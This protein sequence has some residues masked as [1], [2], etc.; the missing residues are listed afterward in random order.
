[1]TEHIRI[2][3]VGP[4]RDLDIP[5]PEGGGVVVLRALNGQGKTTAIEAAARLAGTRKSKLTHR[6]GSAAGVVEGLGATIAVRAT[7]RRTGEPVLGA[8]QVV[9][10]VDPSGLVDPGLKSADAADRARIKH[11]LDITNTTDTR[12][13]WIDHV[14]EEVY[15]SAISP[16]E[17]TTLS[18]VDRCDK[19]K[20]ALEGEARKAE[21]TA[22]QHAGAADAL[23]RDVVSALDGMSEEE[24]LAIPHDADLLREE[25]TSAVRMLAEAE[26]VEGERARHRDAVAAATA[27]LSD[28]ACALPPEESDEAAKRIAKAAMDTREAE[29][30]RLTQELADARLKSQ[31]AEQNFLDAKDAAERNAARRKEIDELQA[32]ID[33]EPK[34]ALAV[35]SLKGAVESAEFALERGAVVRRALPK[36]AELASENEAARASHRRARDMRDTARATDVVLSKLVER[37]GVDGLRVEGGRL[38]AHKEGRPLTFFGDL[39]TGE[40]WRFALPLALRAIGKGGLLALDQAAWEALDPPN[41]DYV[42]S[43]AVD[44]GVWLIAAEAA[45]GE[46]RAEPYVSESG[47]AG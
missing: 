39:S 37:A 7:T 35:A 17:E 32:L 16:D 30:E 19:L 14:G 41:R 40:R 28:V 46:L 31:S 6:D 29:V 42:A 11:L 24:F 3:N 25:H 8:S 2:E 22:E 21:T 26:A 34:E 10:D 18:P 15:A 13:D 44:A 4:I 38:V 20:R 12:E 36:I 1:M 47:G 43:Q 5:L 9:S 23:Q 45:E 33:S 27:K